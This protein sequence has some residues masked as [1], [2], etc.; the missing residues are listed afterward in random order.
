MKPALLLLFSAGAWAQPAWDV[1]LTGGHVIDPRN[2]VNARMDVAISGGKIAAVGQQLPSD[3][4]RKAIF[5]PGLFVVPGLVDIHVHVYN[6]SAGNV[7]A[8]GSLSVQPDAHGPRAGVTTMVDAGSSGYRNFPDFKERIIDRSKT[9]VLAMLNIVGRG[10]AGAVEQDVKEMDPKAAAALAQQHKDVIVGIKTA[11]YSAPDW[12]AVNRAIEAG[13]RAGLPVMV[14][15][16]TFRPQRPFQELVTQVLRKG[17]IYTH[18]YLGAVP[19]LDDKSVLRPYLLDARKRGVI[20]DAGH[21]AGSFLFRQAVPAVKQ[22]LV[23][24]SISTDL[25]AGSMNAGMK[26][27]TNVM[28]KFLNMGL[29][30]EDVILRSTWNPARIIRREDLG[31]LTVG[32]AADIAVLRVEKG[33]FG[34]VDV[35]GARMRGDQLITAEMTIRDGKVIWDRNGRTREDWHTL[36]DYKALGDPLWDGERSSGVRA[37]K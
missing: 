14:D 4:A 29:L 27:M 28:S 19:M 25:H 22:G 35:Y 18:T 9:R 36:G 11:H 37:R 1:L 26:D 21:G 16:G 13:A 7:Y 12:E 31:H 3:N 8:G 30:M 5:V 2:R 34:F 17:D 23:P 24:D 20:F 15:F 32:A 10:M 6:G 33:E